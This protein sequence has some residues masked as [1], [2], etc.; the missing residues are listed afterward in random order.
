MVG[1]LGHY[2]NENLGDEAIIA[3]LIARIRAERSDT[4]IR[5][6][7][8]HP[9]DSS[10]RYGVTA[11]PIRIAGESELP[12][13]ESAS[14]H[15]VQTSAPRGPD[16]DDTPRAA[17]PLANR[18]KALIPARLRAVLSTVARLPGLVR[19]AVDEVGFLVR[20]YRRLRGVDALIVAGSNQFL[21]NFGGPWGFPYTLFKWSLLARLA[22][23]RLLYV[24]VGAGPLD[25]RLSRLLVRAA[26]RFAHYLSFRDAASQRLIQGTRTHRATAVYPDLAH[27]LALPASAS[28]ATGSGVKPVVAI[29]PMPLYDERYWYAT[30][31]KRYRTY[32]SV[33]AALAEHLVDNGYPIFFFP[34]QPKDVSVALDVVRTM[35]PDSAARLAQPDPVRHPKTVGDLMDVISG[36]D[37]VIAT[38]FHGALLSLHARRPVVAICYH[39]K[40][41][42]LMREMGQEQYAIDFDDL[43]VTSL[44]DRFHRLEQNR[45][46]AAAQIK[47]VDVRFFDDLERQYCEFLP[48]IFGAPRHCARPDRQ[49]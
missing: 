18:V 44:V 41:R 39:R 49:G 47:E 16:R 13:N 8:I 25:S 33:L 28:T 11:Y 38:R 43:S 46:D 29:N 48:M 23:C 12:P 42:D 2:G 14:A 19:D 15:V 40:T 31:R 17:T 1:I 7:S 22:G 20:S 37:I 4:D 3:A 26:I 35:R 36:A 10:L 30:D 6:F 32:V 24:S 45:F 27:S 21:D 34:T 9:R 5:C